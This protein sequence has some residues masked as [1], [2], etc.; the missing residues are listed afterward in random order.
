MIKILEKAIEKVRA[1]PQDR[2]AY[3]ALMLEEIAADTADE[4]RLSE[5]ER[6]LNQEAIDELDRGESASEANVR[7]A[8]RQP[9]AW[10]F[11]SHHG[12]S[13]IFRAFVHN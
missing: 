11:A 12:R 1:L 10:A 3:A 4:Y 8:L 5:E 6:R 2:Q 7:S 9:W 13:L